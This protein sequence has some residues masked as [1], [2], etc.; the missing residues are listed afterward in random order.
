LK[1]FQ[2]D[3]KACI[4]DSDAQ[5]FIEN[6]KRKQNVHPSFYF[7]YELDVDGTLTHVFWADGIA[8]FNYS[9]YG[10]VLSFETT[11][12]TNRYKMIFAPFS[13]LDNHRLCVSFGAAFL[14]DETSESFMWLFD[15]FL[16]VMGG[17]MPVCLIIDQ[18]PVMKVAINAK[19]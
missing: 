3:L 5:M 2:R 17:H 6:F 19:F 16:D 4:K 10:D 14:S 15:K 9:L 1:N 13:G 12:D 8:R 7:A 18:D 11:Y